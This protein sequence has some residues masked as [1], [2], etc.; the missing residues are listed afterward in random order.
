MAGMASPSSPGPSPLLAFPGAVAVPPAGEHPSEG[1]ATAGS[2]VA[3]HY[4][5]PMAEQRAAER[6]AVLLDGWAAGTVTVTGPDR[7]SW[8]HNLTTQHVADLTDGTATQALVLSPQGHVEH[9]MLFVESGGTVRLITE[10]GAAAALADY[11]TKMTFWSKVETIDASAD[12]AVL[13]VHGRDADRVVGDALSVPPP[14]AGRAV[15]IETTAGA[16][17]LFRRPADRGGAGEGDLVLSV[18]RA[19]VGALAA[20]LRAAGAVPAGTWAADALR[21]LARRPRFGVDSDERTIPNEMPWLHTALHLQKGCYRGQ[22]TVARVH[23]LGRPPRRLVLLNLDGSADRL[24]EIGD[25]VT[26]ATGRAV[27]RVGSVAYHHEDGPVALAL[28]KRTVDASTPLLAGPVDAAVDPAD[29]PDE[30]SGTPLSAVD[31]R[32]FRSVA[33]G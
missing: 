3:W 2:G 26:L 6:G 13:T 27:G 22:E 18:P 8:L 15:P 23:N 14:A 19:A 30:P 16:G 12:L 29:V 20:T 10:P 17:V 9:E 21:I 5:D 1:G 7:L 33:R 32:A 31:H 24:P 28:V 25:P 11:L 4:G